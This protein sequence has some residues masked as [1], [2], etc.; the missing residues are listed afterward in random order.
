MKNSNSKNSY[1]SLLVSLFLLISLG[2]FSGCSSDN[3]DDV[4]PS[5]P[6]SMDDDSNNG[7]KDK[8][9]AFTLTSVDGNTVSLSDFEDKVV[10]LFFFGN[11]CPTCRAVGPS[12]ESRLNQ[13]FSGD[14]EFA[15]VGL[16]QWDGNSQSVSNFRS[17]TG[18]T[19]DLLLNASGVARDYSTTYDRLIIVDKEGNVDFMGRQI[20]ANDLDVVVQRV[21]ELL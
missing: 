13:S 16:D 14:D 20:A 10:V 6:S 17:T 12:I 4:D 3:N 18:I 19:F 1:L 9:P 5:D 8:A 21:Q 15:I 7:D 11:T 2:I